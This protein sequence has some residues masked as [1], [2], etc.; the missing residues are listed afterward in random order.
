M[1][2]KKG[3]DGS[4]PSLIWRVSM[5]ADSSLSMGTCSVVKEFGP[6]WTQMEWETVWGHQNEVECPLTYSYWSASL[7][8]PAGA[9]SVHS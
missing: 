2:S 8:M 7:T 1:I 4:T 3:F 6:E 9:T 5:G